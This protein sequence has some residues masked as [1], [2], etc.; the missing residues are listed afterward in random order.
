MPHVDY[1]G[2]NC[3]RCDVLFT[4]VAVC[5]F[6]RILSTFECDMEYGYVAVFMDICRCS[7]IYVLFPN[8]FLGVPH[9]SSET[10]IHLRSYRRLRISSRIP[11]S[12]GPGVI[13]RYRDDPV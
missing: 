9:V 2:P 1:A 6:Q 5:K 12:H 11:D 8:P 10:F 13:R 7:Q 4:V 3:C